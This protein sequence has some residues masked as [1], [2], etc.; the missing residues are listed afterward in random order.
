MNDEPIFENAYIYVRSAGKLVG[1][2]WQAWVCVDGK[3]DKTEPK[4]DYDA[5]YAE[6]VSL[7]KKMGARVVE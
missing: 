3:V 1:L 2:E 5:V 7:A 4:K 6:G